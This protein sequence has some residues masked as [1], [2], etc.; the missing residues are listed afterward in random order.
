[1]QDSIAIFGDNKQNS[2][3]VAVAILNALL[4]QLLDLLAASLMFVLK[5]VGDKRQCWGDLRRK[6]LFDLT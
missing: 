2:S 5:D 6:L 1:M 4:D 3:F